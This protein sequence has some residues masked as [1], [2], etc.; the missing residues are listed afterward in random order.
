MKK[1]LIIL[2]LLFVI[3][4][5][6]TVPEGEAT[7]QS[8]A[9]NGVTTEFIFTFACNSVDDI[10]VYAPLTSTGQPTTAL[11]IDTDY[12]VVP[13]GGSYLNGGTVTIDPALAATFKVFIERDIKVSQELSS[14][15]V[16]VASLVLAL[17]KLTREVRDMQD[18]LQRSLRIPGSDDTSFD[19][20][21]PPTVERAGTLLGFDLNGNPVAFSGVI[22]E[23]S[24]S[25]FGGIFIQTANAASGRGLLEVNTQ[26]ETIATLIAQQNT[27]ADTQTF[28]SATFTA[29]PVMPVGGPGF[30]PVGSMSMYA[31][32]T[33]APSGWLLCQGQAVSRTTYSVLFT[34][35][36]TTYGVGDGSTTFNLP[37]MRGKVPLGVGTA[38]PADVPDGTAHALADKEGTE[39]HTLIS[40]ELPA[41]EHR[42]NVWSAGG[43]ALKSIGGTSGVNQGVVTVDPGPTLGSS[44]NNLQPSLTLNFIIKY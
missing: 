14:G 36:T 17:D 31:G 19:M 21:I 35:I 41:H 12:T 26:A 28:P 15:A 37:D 3:P 29:T 32:A 34:L 2:F 44:H 25:V 6:A 22:P 5:F 16:T 38:D 1:A 13:T 7:R 10:N 27:W 43:G 40:D 11:T 42:I 9:C 39:T 30:M 18:R 23:G 20:V 8:F 33:T 4:V 24:T